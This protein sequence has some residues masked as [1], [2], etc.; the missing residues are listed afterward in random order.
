MLLA[1][2]K[3]K[4]VHSVR[5]LSYALCSSISARALHDLQHQRPLLFHGVSL[6]IRLYQNCLRCAYTMQRLG[7]QVRSE[8]AEEVARAV[9]FAGTR[10]HLA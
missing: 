4:R 8:I 2:Y 9:A 6:A 10:S 7:Q 1:T 5:S 3:W